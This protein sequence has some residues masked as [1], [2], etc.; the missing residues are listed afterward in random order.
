M[1][2]PIGG[3]IHVNQQ[4]NAIISKVGNEL[5]RPE[6]QNLVAAEILKDRFKHIQRVRPVENSHKID[7]KTRHEEKKR[8]Q[9]SENMNK[10]AKDSKQEAQEGLEEKPEEELEHIQPSHIDLKI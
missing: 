4:S 10:Q 2:S 8:E 7:S 3:V 9:E 5:S 6:F 1:I